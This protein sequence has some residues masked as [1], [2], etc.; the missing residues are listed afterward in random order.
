MSNSEESKEDRGFKVQDRRRFTAEGEAKAEES[1]SP[2]AP[3]ENPSPPPPRE[4][5]ADTDRDPVA[6]SAS[7]RASAPVEIN[8]STFLISLG[9]QALAYLGEIPN[10]V[11]GSHTI[12][13]PAA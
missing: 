2:S 4:A 13:L 7:G 1:T 3:P 9:T 12:D 5:S 6:S 10:P 8:F 11:D